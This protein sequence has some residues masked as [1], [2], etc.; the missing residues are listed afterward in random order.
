MGDVD[1]MAF[2][3]APDLTVMSPFHQALQVPKHPATHAEETHRVRA[4]YNTIQYVCM[5]MV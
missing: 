2:S 5:F 4:Y 1:Q 3:S